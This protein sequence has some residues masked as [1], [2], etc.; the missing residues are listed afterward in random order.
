MEEA[1]DE[2]VGRGT[3]QAPETDGVVHLPAD[4]ATIG[5]IIEVRYVDSDGIDLK[6]EPA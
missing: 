4:A 2:V 6:G 1:G 5:S 3:H